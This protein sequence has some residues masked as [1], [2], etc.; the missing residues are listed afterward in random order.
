[1]FCDANDIDL[2]DMEQRRGPIRVHRLQKAIPSGTWKR[3]WIDRSDPPPVRVQLA[4]TGS[5]R[6]TSSRRCSLIP[7]RWRS[8]PHRVAVIRSIGSKIESASEAPDI[9]EGGDGLGVGAVSLDRSV[10]GRRNTS[11]AALPWC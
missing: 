4:H 7:K 9:D 5:F 6:K 11:F 1:M 10:G 3:C 2:D 8:P